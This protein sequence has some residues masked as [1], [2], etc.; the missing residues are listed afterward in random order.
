MS[1]IVERLLAL[2]ERERPYGSLPDV[3]EEAAAEITK[4]RV[5]N[6]LLKSMLPPG[7]KYTTFR[8]GAGEASDE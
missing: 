1:D 3:M 4:L 8:I 2:A 6:I 7:Y 5:D